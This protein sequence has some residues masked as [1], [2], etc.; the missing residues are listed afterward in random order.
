MTAATGIP[1]SV[2]IPATASTPANSA[3]SAIAS[4]PATAEIPTT[5]ER[6]QQQEQCVQQQGKQQHHRLQEQ[7]PTPA[8]MT[9]SETEV[10]AS[11]SRDAR[12]SEMPATVGTP[13]TARMPAALGH[14]Q[15]QRRLATDGTPPVTAGTAKAVRIRI[16]AIL[17]TANGMETANSRDAAN[18]KTRKG[19]SITGTP[20]EQ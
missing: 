5:G 13:E 9:I 17:G 15:E 2:E 6:Q 1:A 16:P 4:N 18:S 20:T 11:N 19:N 10:S 8:T 7:V 3:T 12:N 14:K